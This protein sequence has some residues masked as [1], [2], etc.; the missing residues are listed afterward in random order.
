MG[1]APPEAGSCLPTRGARKEE[2]VAIETVNGV[3]LRY[4]LSGTGEVPV[5]LVHGAWV[6]LYVGLGSVL[7]GITAAFALGIA[8]FGGNT[9]NS[10]IPR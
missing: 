10:V 7:I 5:V 3:R 4:N 1:N 9:P 8:S 6:S 2:A